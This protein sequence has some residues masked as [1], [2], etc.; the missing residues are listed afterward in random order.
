MA[1]AASSGALKKGE[2]I[3]RWEQQ[4]SANAFSCH[5]QDP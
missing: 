1:G 4:Q 5:H 3:S 2:A